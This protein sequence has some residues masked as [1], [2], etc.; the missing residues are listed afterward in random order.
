MSF[1]N[2]AYPKVVIGQVF[3][4]YNFSSSDLSDNR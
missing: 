3:K 1:H 4:K 2:P